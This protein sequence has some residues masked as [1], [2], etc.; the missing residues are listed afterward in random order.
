MER[1]FD[2]HISEPV[3]APVLELEGVRARRGSTTVLRHADLRVVGGEVVGIVGPN[4]VGKSTLL[5]VCAGLIRPAE[6]A[7]YHFGDPPSVQ[8]LHR[9]GA[10]IDTPSFYPWMSGKGVLVTLLQLRGVRT[11]HE[12]TE[13]MARFDLANNR[14]R[15][16]TFSQGMKKRLALAAASLN[17]PRLLILDEPTNALDPAGREIVEAWIRDQRDSGTAI[18]IATHVEREI[19]LCSRIVELDDGTIRLRAEGST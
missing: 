4:G 9:I 16:F 15:V 12:A 6:G 14:Q 8:T 11:K 7:V 2:G 1:D 13:A 18:L 17:A 3:T 5:R 19:A 10:A